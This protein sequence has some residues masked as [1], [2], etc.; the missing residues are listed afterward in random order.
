MIDNPRVGFSLIGLDEA[1]RSYVTEGI[2]FTFAE[3]F[4][5]GYDEE[6]AE[7]WE[8]GGV[9]A[10]HEK[11]MKMSS[12]A[13]KGLSCLIHSRVPG[14]PL[15]RLILEEYSFQLL[16]EVVKRSLFPIGFQGI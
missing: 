8:F 7:I 3:D 4:L 2:L 6:E 1:G 16:S 5:V 10:R 11:A 13:L 12:H 15:S 14:A 9:Q